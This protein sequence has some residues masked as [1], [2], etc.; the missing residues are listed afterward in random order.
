MDKINETI[1][2][3]Q[4]F[5]EFNAFA[6]LHPTLLYQVIGAQQHFIGQTFGT[7]TWRHYTKKRKSIS[8]DT[9]LK[10][11]S[12]VNPAFFGTKS[13][14][15]RTS[16]HLENSRKLNLSKD[17][18]DESKHTKSIRKHAQDLSVINNTNAPNDT[19]PGRSPAHRVDRE[20]TQ[21]HPASSTTGASPHHRPSHHHHPPPSNS[22]S[23]PQ[24]LPPSGE[25][26]MSHTSDQ[27]NHRRQTYGGGGGGGGRSEDPLGI[28]SAR[29]KLI[30]IILTI[31]L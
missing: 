21:P 13:M 23:H 8:T 15:R 22:H 26:K 10:V 1:H 29:S 16:N 11:F 30:Y 25:Q 3:S 17:P 27:S 4:T 28:E 5:D 19:Y 2:G 24:A 9:V 14:N 31:I 12:D 7:S 6:K 18:L 20:E